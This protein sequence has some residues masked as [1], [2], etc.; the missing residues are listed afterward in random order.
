MKMKNLIKIKSVIRGSALL[1]LAAGMFSC[2]LN[3]YNPSGATADAVWSTQDGI[4]TAVNG[5]YSNLRAQF[6]GREDIMYFSETGTDIWFNA[7]RRNYLN[8]IARYESLTPSLGQDKNTWERLYAPINICNAGIE[9]IKDVVYSDPKLKKKREGELRFLRAYYYW[10]LVETFGG[11]YLSTTETKEP[12]LKLYRSSVED[13]YKV[14]IEDLKFAVNN[15][16]VETT[17]AQSGRATKKAAS[18]LLARVYLTWASH[19]QY[20]SNKTTEAKTYY[21]QAFDAAK[22]VIDKQDSLGVS[23]YSSFA[24]IFKPANNKTNKEALFVVSHTSNTALEVNS[25]NPNRLHMWY[26]LPYSGR[27]G[28]VKSLD[29]GN[30]GSGMLMPTKFLLNLFDETKDGRYYGSF[31]ETWLRNNATADKWTAAFVSVFKKPSSFTGQTITF[32]VG[33]TA[34]YISKKPIADKSTRRYACLDINDIYDANTDSVMNGEQRYYYPVLT[35]F[36]DPDRTATNSQ[37]GYKNIIV[38]RLA[39]M[40]LIAAEAAMQLDK[41]DVAATYINVLRTRA[42]IKTPVDKTAAMQ[43]SAN[44]INLDF[45]LNERARELCGEHLRWFDLKRTRQLENRLGLGKANPDIRS[46]DKNVH[47][48]RPVPQTFLDAI[49]NRDEFGQNPGY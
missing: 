20:D 1:C 11:V 43:V 4:E 3:E 48:L 44:D 42:A 10:H 17:E 8:Q 29:Y 28:L 18:G 26:L 33:D 34:L 13:F 19:L 22:Y 15:L 12:M 2:D 24:D 35:K 14:M 38:M 25:G 5:A 27:P 6:Y 40:Y 37:A 41:K 39:E 16:Q 36:M 23:L 32:P 7:N 30:D 49:L 46:F 31:Q 47:Y 45:I 21:Q 9:R